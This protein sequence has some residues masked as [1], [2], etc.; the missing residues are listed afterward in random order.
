M[1]RIRWPNSILFSFELLLVLSAPLFAQNSKP[2]ISPDR[3]SVST[4]SSTVP[5]GSLLVETGINYFSLED[6]EENLRLESDGW[7]TP[8]LLRIGLSTD[9]ELRLG[10]NGAV[11]QDLELKDGGRIEDDTIH[12]FSS[13]SIGMKWNFAHL[14]GK[15]GK[16]SVALIA[17]LNLPAG[18]DAF[19]P[20]EVEPDFLLAVDIS[21]PRQF[22]LAAN[23]G[24]GIPEDPN[25]GDRFARGLGSIAVGRSL[26]ENTSFYAE[27]AVIGPVEEGGGAQFLVNGGFMFRLSHNLQIDLAVFRGL[28]EVTNDWEITFGFS[29]RPF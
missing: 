3:P 24:I 10:T 19:A 9:L 16:P 27:T 21:L 17:N 20:D 5:A 8:L 7:F 15:P 29:F 13:P 18:S 2:P 26:S 1:N 11:W 22:T 12:G 23:G 28:T 6:R 14:E 4:S 25:S